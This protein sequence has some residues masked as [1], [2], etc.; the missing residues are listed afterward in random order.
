MQKKRRY[1]IVG[2][3]TLGSFLLLFIAFSVKNQSTQQNLHQAEN[4]KLAA[5]LEPSKSSE[6]IKPTIPPDEDTVNQIDHKKTPNEETNTLMDRLEATK[7]WLENANSAHYTIQLFGSNNERVLEGRLHALAKELDLK[8]IYLFRTQ[9]RQ[10]YSISVLYNSFD[11]LEHA[12]SSLQSLP[13][14][15]KKNNP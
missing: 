1:T 14:S 8:K 6:T 2:I 3:I 7:I 11:S 5:D 4:Q 10:S 15:I 9:A 13:D 12:E